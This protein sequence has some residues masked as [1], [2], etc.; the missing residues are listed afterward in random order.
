MASGSQ[1]R[2]KEGFVLT[3]NFLK[4]KKG[5]FAAAASYQKLAGFS[6]WREHSGP[7]YISGWRYE[8]EWARGKFKLDSESAQQVPCTLQNFSAFCIKFTFHVW[9][10][11]TRERWGWF[12]QHKGDP[13]DFAAVVKQSVG[14]LF[15][16]AAAWL[17][18][19]GGVRVLWRRTGLLLT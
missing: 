18:P 5:G 11:C 19:F 17:V 14:D 3:V 6:C 16:L 10:R 8:G 13:S 15:V 7:L 9:Q 2:L 1:R 4:G 12:K